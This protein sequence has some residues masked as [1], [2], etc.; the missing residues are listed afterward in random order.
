MQ[1]LKRIRQIFCNN[2]YPDWYVNN[3]VKKFEKRQNYPPN[4]Y[5]PDFLF[6]LRIP[7]FKKGSR[8]LAKRLTTLVKT[9]FDVDINVHYTKNENKENQT[10]GSVMNYLNLTPI[11]LKRA[12][13]VKNGENWERPFSCSGANR[14]LLLMMI[15]VLKQN[16]VFNLS[17]L[18]CFL[19]CLM[20]CT[21]VFIHVMRIFRTSVG[22]RDILALGF[23]NICT[24]KPQNQQ[25]VMTLK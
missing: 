18:L 19:Y 5:E 21:D 14:L 22:L 12:L 1:E 25:F 20:S 10:L 24:T 4:K 9:K 16:R 17:A 6:T 13:I 8:V 7:F 11:R 2:G 23:R 3:I 15:Y